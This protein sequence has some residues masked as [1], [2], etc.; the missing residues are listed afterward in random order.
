MCKHAQLVMFLLAPLDDIMVVVRFGYGGD[1]VSGYGGGV[2]HRQAG[3]QCCVGT[4][5]A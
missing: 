2:G 1:D 4:W 3:T 5:H